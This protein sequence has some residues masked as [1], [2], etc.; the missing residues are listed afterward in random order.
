M[1]ANLNGR[2]QELFAPYESAKT[3]EARQFSHFTDHKP[4][5][6]ASKQK[7]EKDSPR[8]LQKLD[9]ISQ[10]ITDIQHISSHDDIPADTL[11]HVEVISLEIELA[12]L[13]KQQETEDKLQK[14]LKPSAPL[15]L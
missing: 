5:T 1:T 12:I 9:Y 6:Y 14:V 13:S 7:S 8:Q 4:L 11:P 2:N 10:F 15:Q 3:L